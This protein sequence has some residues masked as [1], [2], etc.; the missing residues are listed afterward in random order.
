MKL[1]INKEQAHLIYEALEMQKET[2]HR[3]IK[4]M[5]KMVDDTN[6]VLKY[7]YNKY[8]GIGDLMEAIDLGISNE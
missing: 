2:V 3:E 8:G 1:I 5:S 6:P 4:T 7:A